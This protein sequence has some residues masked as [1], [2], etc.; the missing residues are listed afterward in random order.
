MSAELYYICLYGLLIIATTLVQQLTS[1]VNVGIMPV[2][3]SREGVNFSGIT[4]RLERAILNCVIALA[5]IAPAILAIEMTETSNANTI[6]AVQVFFWARLVYL[7]AYGLN[8]IGVRSGSWVASLLSILY[9]YWA[10][11]LI[12]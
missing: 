2:F 10:A 3:G 5:M 6:L 12:S 9:L 7:I 8:I 1:I 4:G 11:L